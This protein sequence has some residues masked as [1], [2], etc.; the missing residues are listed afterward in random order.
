M[1]AVTLPCPSEECEFDIT[2]ILSK[3]I[4]KIVTSEP[5]LVIETDAPG[6]FAFIDLGFSGGIEQSTPDAH[7]QWQSQRL[8]DAIDKESGS[9]V[10]M[11]GL[12]AL[13]RRRSFQIDYKHRIVRFDTPLPAGATEVRLARSFKEFESEMYAVSIHLADHKGRSA[14]AYGFVDTG[15]PRSYILNEAFRHELA[16]LGMDSSCSCESIGLQDVTV[17]NHNLT[18][19]EH[20]IDLFLAGHRLNNTLKGVCDVSECGS[21]HLNTTIRNPTIKPQVAVSLGNDSLSKLAYIYIDLDRHTLFVAPAPARQRLAAEPEQEPLD[22]GEGEYRTLLFVISGAIFSV[23]LIA[24][25][26]PKKSVEEM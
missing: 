23:L 9:K 17:Q 12:T 6:I 7:G 18:L 21:E 25:F 20:Q 11:V 8:D 10:L 3:N 15:N 19:R 14:P 26:R 13:K 24:L 22:E 4:Y 1:K 2:E 5:Y 16:D